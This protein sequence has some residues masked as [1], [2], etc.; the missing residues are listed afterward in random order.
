[1]VA[2]QESGYA[3]TPKEAFAP[4]VFHEVT[5]VPGQ[6]ASLDITRDNIG[7]P[8]GLSPEEPLSAGM[9]KLAEVVG[10]DRWN[11]LVAQT[12][13]D[14]TP[15]KSAA[16]VSA[17]EATPAVDERPPSEWSTGDWRIS[18]HY[19]DRAF[20]WA[21]TGKG[22][23]S[24]RDAQA[25]F[26]QSLG[27]FIDGFPEGEGEMKGLF[28]AMLE[29]GTSGNWEEKPNLA[30]QVANA[31]WDVGEQVLESWTAQPQVLSVAA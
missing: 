30:R 29:I 16:F 13:S 8:I 1:M 15:E 10:P 24:M 7:P 12:K 3:P 26:A 14:K 5:L 6:P 22:P 31:Y 20:V 27:R 18:R 28:E 19:T 4:A 21:E 9:L 17:L 11:S 25:G 23:G 2:T